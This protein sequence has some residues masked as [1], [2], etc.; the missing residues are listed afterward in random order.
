MP[1]LVLTFKSGLS[2][3]SKFR[4][5]GKSFRKFKWLAILN[6][7]YSI[8]ASKY[9]FVISSILSWLCFKCNKFLH[10]LWISYTYMN[11]RMKIVWGIHFQYLTLEHRCNLFFSNICTTVISAGFCQKVE[12]H[13]AI[14]WCN[15]AFW[16][17]LLQPEK[18]AREAKYYDTFGRP[19]STYLLMYAD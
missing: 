17:Y 15:F 18:A 11:I 14:F 13:K 2:L 10:L 6:S 3:S 4:L 5:K 12:C 8:S 1:Y 19:S 7:M 9:N 16:W